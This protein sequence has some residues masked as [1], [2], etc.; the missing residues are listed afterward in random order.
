MPAAAL[1]PQFLAEYAELRYELHS[2]SHC[3]VTPGHPESYTGPNRQIESTSPALAP[4]T[5]HHPQSASPMQ[6][7]GQPSAWTGG[8]I[9][10]KDMQHLQMAAQKGNMDARAVLEAYSSRGQSAN[11]NQT[12]GNPSGFVPPISAELINKASLSKSPMAK[13]WLATALKQNSEARL[14]Y[15]YEH[16][17]G[18]T[19]Y[20][21]DAKTNMQQL[22]VEHG[23]S[24]LTDAQNDALFNPKTGAVATGK[25]DPNRINGKTARIIADAYI[26][27]PDMS[28]VDINANAAGNKAT[29]IAFDKG[30]QGDIVRSMNVSINHLTTLSELSDALGNGDIKSINNIAQRYK[31][32]TGNPAP[33]NFDTAKRI[34]AG[35]I[36]KGIVGAGGTGEDRAKAAETIDKVKSPAQLKGAIQTYIQL[37]GGQLEGLGTQYEAGTGKKDFK[38]KYLNQKTRN[39]IGV[40]SSQS[41]PLKAAYDKY[42]LH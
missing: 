33:T 35:E 13:Q 15:Q 20:S 27:N 14:A 7:Q 8:D 30:K 37:L 5:A 17:S 3:Q 19:V 26:K 6:P 1:P 42:G 32:E 2:Q 21:T 9:S 18:S 39:A 12:I 23:T 28:F 10:T 24:G 36:V 31:E 4:P 25:V 16:P 41:D 40:S 22:K 34:I 38:D 11:T 29:V